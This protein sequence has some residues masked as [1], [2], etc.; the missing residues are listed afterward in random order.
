MWNRR[1]I[2]N[3]LA[4]NIREES[5]KL[6][7]YVLIYNIVLSILTKNVNHLN[8]CLPW[9]HRHQSTPLSIFT[10]WHPRKSPAIANIASTFEWNKNIFSAPICPQAKQNHQ[11]SEFEEI[12][13][14]KNLFTK[15]IPR[16]YNLNPRYQFNETQSITQCWLPL[17]GSTSERDFGRGDLLKL[18]FSDQFRC[19]VTRTGAS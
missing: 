11:N 17:P 19:G 14:K 2:L 12:E 7:F 10:K 9:H 13:G 18:I 8:V 15:G 16:R 5:L 4:F 3:R 6:I 1:E